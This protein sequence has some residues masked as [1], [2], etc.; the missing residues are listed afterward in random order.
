MHM[1]KEQRAFTALYGL[2]VLSLVA[3]GYSLYAEFIQHMPVCTL[4]WYQRIG[5]YGLALILTTGL[6]SE[7]MKS[8]H[9]ALPFSWLVILVSSIH[10]LTQWMPEWLPIS[11]CTLHGPSCQTKHLVLWGWVTFPALSLAYG[12]VMAIGLHWISRETN[13]AETGSTT[14]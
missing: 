7:D 10:L 3:L 4:C 1:R 9:Y 11:L 14:W 12:L 8:V 2:W 13:Y 6:L 5:A